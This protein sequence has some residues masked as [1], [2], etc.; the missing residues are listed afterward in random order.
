MAI[1]KKDKKKATAIIVNT[2]EKTWDKDEKIS[3]QQVVE[4][5]FDS[6]SDDENVVYTVTYS[7]GASPK[8]EGSLVKGKSVKVKDGMLFNVTQTNKS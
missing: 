3:Y 8:K 1:Q 4:L 2:R 5:A 7:N 6:C